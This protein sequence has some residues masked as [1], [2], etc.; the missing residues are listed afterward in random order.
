MVWNGRYNVELAVVKNSSE[1][2]AD[3]F[4]AV[5]Q[6]ELVLEEHIKYV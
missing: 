5:D 1:I 3:T 6:L 2:I 4:E